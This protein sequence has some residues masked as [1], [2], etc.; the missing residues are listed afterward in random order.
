MALKVDS[1]MS[2][3]CLMMLAFML[4]GCEHRELV[5][6]YNGHYLRIY[7]DE[8]IKNV[9]YGFFDE[10]RERPEYIRPKALRVVLTD[11]ITD[12]IITERY[13]QT[14]GEDE[15]GYYI[16]GY[17]SAVEG[18]YNMIV[19]NFGTERTKVRKEYNYNEM[20]AYTSNIPE[21]YYKYFPSVRADLDEKTI[22][23]CPDHLF[24]AKCQP[25]KI[26]KSEY[27]DT[28]RTA[29]GDFFTAHSIVLSYYIQVKIKGLNY[30]RTAVSLLSGMAGSTTL[31]NSKMNSN[32]PV[33][34]FFDMKYTDVKQVREDN[35]KTAIL[36]TTFNTFGK[37]PDQ[38]NIYTLN[39][40]FTR[41]DGTSQVETID[42]T[43]MFDDPMVVNE[44]WILLEKEI[45]ID[46]PS[47]DG[48][49]LNPGVDEWGDVWTDI[50]L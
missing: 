25:I 28:L 11:P 35:K 15:R 9:T 45:E 23:Y 31:C 4:F 32:D 50:Q 16:D 3:V 34:I 20:Q 10:N 2:Y 8:Q 47:G 41:S 26:S 39:F 1:M 49:G 48:G 38:D 6:P 43:S 33:N 37:L 30:V 46:P 42:I 27:V 5:N 36:Y 7:I 44:R 24:L 21:S 40:E 17:I 18:D 29:E 13:L 22:R 14:F 19:Y 12:E